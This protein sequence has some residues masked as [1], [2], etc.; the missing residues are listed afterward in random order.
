MHGQIFIYC[1]TI[2]QWELI[3]RAVSMHECQE[4]LCWI[5]KKWIQGMQR[6]KK[7]L[8][9]LLKKVKWINI[10]TMKTFIKENLR[11]SKE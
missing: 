6:E 4:Y 2:Q 10:F 9:K 7:H 11:K 1:N 8:G 3:T 5:L